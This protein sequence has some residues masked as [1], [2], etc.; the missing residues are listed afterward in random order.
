MFKNTIIILALAIT[1]MLAQ[2]KAF[3]KKDGNHISIGNKYIERVINISPRDVGTIQIKN[4]ISGKTY[5]VKSDE[6]VL[7]VVFS[8]VGPA[9][10]KE[11]NG[12]NQIGS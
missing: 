10:S 7:R 6:F 5:N 4:R 12:E 1:S 3:I 9:Y 8:G 11:Q 2:N